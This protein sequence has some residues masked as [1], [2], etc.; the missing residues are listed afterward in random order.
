LDRKLIDLEQTMIELRM[1]GRG[2][3]GVRWGAKLLGKLGYLANGL[4][5]GDFKPTDQQ[6]EVQ[7]ELS[8]RARG[9]QRTLDGILNADSR[10][11]TSCFA[12]NIP[13]IKRATSLGG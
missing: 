8:E 13:M 7:K 1:T 5:S 10:G 9:H 4:A 3:D 6:R 12:R 2:Q 11:S